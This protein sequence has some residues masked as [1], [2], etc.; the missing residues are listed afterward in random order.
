M[1]NYTFLSSNF[2]EVTMCILHLKNIYLSKRENLANASLFL[3]T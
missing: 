2:N 1:L 3:K